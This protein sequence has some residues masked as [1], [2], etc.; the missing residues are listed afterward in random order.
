[1]IYLNTEHSTHINLNDPLGQSTLHGPFLQL[2][3]LYA[4]SAGQAAPYSYIYCS[5]AKQVHYLC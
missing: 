1:M 4:T 2:L 3:S 5:P